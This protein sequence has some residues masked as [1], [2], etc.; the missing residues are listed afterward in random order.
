MT[1]RYL[2]INGWYYWFIYPNMLNRERA[3]D[4]KHQPIPRSLS[5]PARRFVF[6][7]S[8]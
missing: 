5:S 1:N 8:E 2:K 7:F 3:D 6:E 4:R